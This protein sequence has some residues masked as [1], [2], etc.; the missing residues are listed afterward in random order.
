MSRKFNY[1][2]K[3]PNVRT[4]RWGDGLSLGFPAN[5]VNPQDSGAN[6]YIILDADTLEESTILALGIIIKIA[7]LQK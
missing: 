1:I 3:F 6:D 5:F 7:R 4:F 2:L